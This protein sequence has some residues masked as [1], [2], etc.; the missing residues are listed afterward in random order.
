MP[1]QYLSARSRPGLVTTVGVISIVVACLNGLGGLSGTFSAAMFLTARAM[2][3]PPA[4]TATPIV[5]TTAPTSP[6]APAGA[7]PT[8]AASGSST[9]VVT[10]TTT[11][12]GGTFSP[13]GVINPTAIRLAL[14]TSVVGLGLAILLLVAGIQLLRDSPNAVRMHWW[15]A[16][17]KIPLVIAATAASVWLWSSLM[18]S[19]F[20]PPPGS[21]A[22][23]AAP[24]TAPLQSM[25]MHISTLIG[26]AISLTYPVALIFLLR[27]RTLRDYFH[28]LHA[29]T[30]PLA[31]PS[32]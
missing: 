18:Q 25:M 20:V 14:A 12:R 24:P 15:Y 7:P 26:A 27:T 31:A 2:S 21:P 10:T 28:A 19:M 6:A 8:T 3:P 4:P 30:E 17:L 9:V 22:T 16:I 29:A 11:T 23:V 1:L 5:T 32:R 13:F